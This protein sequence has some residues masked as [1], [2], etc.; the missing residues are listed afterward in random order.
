MTTVSARP[1]DGLEEAGVVAGETD[2]PADMFA[3]WHTGLER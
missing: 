3:T 2:V 1:T